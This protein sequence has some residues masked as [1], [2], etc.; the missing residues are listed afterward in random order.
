MKKLYKYSEYFGRAGDLE[1]IFVAEERDIDQ[2]MGGEV[3]FGEVLGKHSD[4]T[5]TID[6]DTILILT[7]DQDFIA[8]FEEYGLASGTNIVEQYLEQESENDG[9]EE[10]QE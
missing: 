5:G 4:I 2:S 8:K 10:E 3:N 1:G 7:E 9:Y 6:K